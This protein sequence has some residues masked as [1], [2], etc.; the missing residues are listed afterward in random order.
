MTFRPTLRRLTM[1]ALIGAVTAGCAA[2]PV[3]T[4]ALGRAA[5]KGAA[6]SADG[7]LQL[8]VMPESGVDAILGAIQGAKKSIK[9]KIYMLTNHDA[10]SRVVQA[11]IE[12]AKAGVEVNVV[13]EGRPFIPPSPPDCSPVT[14]NPN[15]D[16]YNALKAGGVNVHFSWK[17]FRYT[18]EK[19]MVIDDATAYIMTMNFTNSAFTTNREYVVVDRT[20]SDV[21]EVKKI[22]ECDWFHQAYQP[23]DPD[24]VISPDN[25][26]ARILKL[27]DSATRTIVIQVEYLKD[28][29]V[30]RHLSDRVKA[31]VDVRAMLSYVPKSP[32]DTS[33]AMA[34]ESKL[35][36]DAGITQFVFTQTVKMH[37]KTIIVDSERAYVGSENLT[38]NSLDGNREMGILL[39]DKALVDVLERTAL[40]DWAAHLQPQ[41]AAPGPVIAPLAD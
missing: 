34:G 14:T 3:A 41:A 4:Q 39:S 40:S 1:A 36:Q 22:F 38:S 29:E 27:V 16:A 26:R 5:M 25:S 18:H 37:A 30:L 33:D 28:P 31:G 32:C 21:A 12:R 20:P 23:Q 11:L 7:Q 19:T 10:S 35:L 17:Q 8:L 9:L 24:L 15:D 2:A 6:R 13:L